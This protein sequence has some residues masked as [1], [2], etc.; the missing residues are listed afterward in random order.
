M[1]AEPGDGKAARS[2]ATICHRWV[3]GVKLRSYETQVKMSKDPCRGINGTRPNS[4][5]NGALKYRATSYGLSSWLT[6]KELKNDKIMD[7]GESTSVDK[8]SS[9]VEKEPLMPKTR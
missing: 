2:Q 1:Y 5:T 7:L 9:E 4:I 3:I 6:L 8:I